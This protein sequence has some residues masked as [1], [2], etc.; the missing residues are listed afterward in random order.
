MTAKIHRV[1]SVTPG[2]SH[3]EESMFLHPCIRVNG[4]GG[5]RTRSVVVI[6]GLQSLMDRFVWCRS[7]SER[8]PSLRRRTAKEIEEKVLRPA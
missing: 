7:A 5:R 3:A 6:V 2:F 8:L 1:D 4:G